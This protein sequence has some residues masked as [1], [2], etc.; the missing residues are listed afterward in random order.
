M[1]PVEKSEEYVQS[2]KALLANLDETVN[3]LGKLAEEDGTL[4]KEAKALLRWKKKAEDLQK[5]VEDWKKSLN[6]DAE[7]FIDFFLAF[8]KRHPQ[9]FVAFFNAYIKTY[10][11]KES[12]IYENTSENVNRVLGNTS[13]WDALKLLND[14]TPYHPWE[15]WFTCSYCL[16][17]SNDVLSMIVEEPTV[18]FK[19]LAM[20]YLNH[21]LPDKVQGQMEKML[22][23]YEMKK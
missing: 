20:K 14:S 3:A 9:E 8:S 1:K 5:A 22:K 21:E 17:S 15:R 12:P 18:F 23:N 6:G 11:N 16:A 19:K 13:H 10:L 4:E 7:E 2:V